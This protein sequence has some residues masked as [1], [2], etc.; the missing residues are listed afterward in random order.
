MQMESVYN[1]EYV[2]IQWYVAMVAESMKYFTDPR[3]GRSLLYLHP[4][5]IY[6][7]KWASFCL[8]KRNPWVEQMNMVMQR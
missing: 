6:T 5:P 8:N 4:E 2:L 7:K 3:T 1:K